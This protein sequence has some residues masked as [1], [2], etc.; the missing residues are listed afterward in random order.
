MFHARAFAMAVA[1]GACG[2]SN[3]STEPDAE[4]PRDTMPGDTPPPSAGHDLVYDDALGVILLVNAGLGG[5]TTPPR[6]QPTV[7]WSWDGERW[8]VLDASGPPIRNLGGVAYDVAR[9]VLVL[10]GGGYSADLSYGDTWEWRRTAGWQRIDVPGPGIRDHTR[11]AYDAAHA[12]V[13]LFGG[14]R[15][16]TAF[17]ADTWAW[18]GAHWEQVAQSGPSARVHHAMAYDPVAQQVV[19]F[20]GYE[21]NVRD[22]GDT[23][24]WNGTTWAEQPPERASRTH[25]RMAFDANLGGLV[26]VGTGTTGAN[27]VRHG[28]AWDSLAATGGPRARYLPGVAFD[29]RRR[30]LVVFGGGDPSSDALFAD[31]WELDGSGWHAR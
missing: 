29:A 27:L 24:A 3:G 12:R 31:L 26:V 25:A 15:S 2:G 1:L 8:S 30:V 4:A 7:L 17:P 10:H 23:W 28:T 16:L 22:H 21:P 5:A 6:D 20:G 14:Q 18:D 13:V 9:D 19:A 11:M